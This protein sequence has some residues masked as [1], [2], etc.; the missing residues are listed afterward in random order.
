M[1]DQSV[2]D[3]IITHENVIVA[4]ISPSIAWCST[5]ALFFVAYSTDIALFVVT[6]V[7]HE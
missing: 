1:L 3:A 2:H 5:V 6:D 4:K 7:T